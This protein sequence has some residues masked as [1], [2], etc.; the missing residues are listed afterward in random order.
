MEEDIDRLKEWLSK[1]PHLPN[2]IDEE[3]LGAYVNGTKSLEIAKQKIDSWFTSRGKIPQLFSYEVRN[4][5][6]PEYKEACKAVKMWFMPKPTPEGYRILCL[7]TGGDFSKFNHA[8]KIVRCT[9]M[10]EVALCMWPDMKGLFVIYDLDRIPSNILT[11]LSLTL[12][13]A[14]LHWFQ[15]T[16]P[17]KLKKVLVV[18]TLPFI[19]LVM[20]TAIKPFMKEKLYN[21]I[22][23]S[24]EGEKFIKKY[25]SDD[26]L[27]MDYGGTEKHSDELNEEWL[28]I[29]EERADWFK[30]TATLTSDEKKR[31]ADKASTYGV[32]GTFRSLAID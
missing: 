14:G 16:F 18:N 7:Q 5:F 21:R 4:P 10:I 11:K 30:R 31:P 28:K 17:V 12:T 24:Q 1:Q 8:Q 19:D 2:D 23:L 22:S 25:L 3:L 13:A 32:E 27:P 9:M 6:S 29:I 26:L 15:N 20:S